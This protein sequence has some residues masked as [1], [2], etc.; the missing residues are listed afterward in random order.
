[1][2]KFRVL[3]ASVNASFINGANYGMFNNSMDMALKL[4]FSSIFVDGVTFHFTPWR[5]LDDPSLLG[6]TQFAA[7]A[8]AFIAIPTGTADVYE[9]GSTQSKP[10]LSLRYRRD[11]AVDRKRQVKIFGLGGTPQKEDK[12]TANFLSEMTNQLVGANAYFIGRKSA[13]YYAF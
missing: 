6:A 11:G 3:C 2:A 9:N 10:Y 1:M 5:L 7:T 4:D 13:A 8:P 12:M